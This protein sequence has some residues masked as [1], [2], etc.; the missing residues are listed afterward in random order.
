MNT[1]SLHLDGRR[2]LTTGLAGLAHTLL[3][4]SL[5]C[6]KLFDRQG[7]L[8]AMNRQGLIVME[9]DDLSYLLGQ[10]WENLWPEECKPLIR[11]MLQAALDGETIDFSAYCPTAKGT[12]RWW[13]V[14]VAPVRNDRGV[15]DGVLCIGRDVTLMQQATGK[16]QQS[17]DM[18][19]KLTQQAPG[20]LYQFRM[21]PDGRFSIPYVGSATE[22]LFEIA[23]SDLQQDASLF[24][25]R[26][27]EKDKEV[28]FRSVYASA[29]SLLPWHLE[30]RLLLPDQGLCWREG[31]SNPE[32]LEDG[33]VLWHGFITDIT[34]RKRT[35]EKFQQLHS[36]LQHQANHDALTGL[37][38][39]RLFRDRLD[40]EIRH[41]Q[42]GARNIALLFLDIDRF[43]EVND[44]LGHEG[45]DML[46]RQ[47][48]SRVQHCV[49]PTDTIARLGGDEFTIILTELADVDGVAH[50]ARR[51]L[52]ALTLPFYIGQQEVRVSASIGITI[53]PTDATSAET[54][55]CNA[56]QAMYLSKDAG[57]NE[58]SFFKQS[59]QVA[60]VERLQLIS[61][62]R[63]AVSNRQLEVHFQPIVDMMTGVIVKAEALV[64][65][66][67]PVR[68]MVPP[69]EFIGVAEETG[70]INDIGDWVFMEAAG[71]AKRWST[72]LGKP[73]QVSI[74][75]SPVQ[76]L[77][78][79]PKLDWLAYLAELDLPGENIVIEITEG[80]LLNL[81]DK[82]LA[83]LKEL[84]SAGVRLAM[85]DFGTGYSS[86]SYL[87]KLDIDYLKI[88]Q[89]FVRDML[90]N[91]TSKTIAKTIIMMGHQLG[92]KVIAEGVELA[93]QH[94]WLHAEGCDYAQGYL[95][96]KPVPPVIFEELLFG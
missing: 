24:F 50:I 46:L 75:K 22:N 95:Y 36:E 47:T 80:V 13:D 91:D 21:W 17:Y 61:E 23:P 86:M 31:N 10:N 85:D 57:R 35:E 67:H 56:D 88:D 52:D 51:I 84:C 28:F 55:V 42:S 5:D 19:F 26:V 16:L 2:Y 71:H 49:R 58:F 32:K 93:E 34:E 59:M 29:A 83:R 64:R 63:R 96:S 79:E 39:R 82:V 20:V 7:R 65:W 27:Y 74:N 37:P 14:R 11:S 53:Y 38:N 81:S 43:K 92:L 78:D 18:L 9:I 76:L 30:F 44:V 4:S 77:Q 8:V 41:A 3:D 72:A 89:S 66:R 15:I 94:E 12:P 45:G 40:Q 73:F 70:L 54:L 87:K 25:A 90:H 68:G 62:L 60:A 69:A 1:V 48:A 6:V 33:S